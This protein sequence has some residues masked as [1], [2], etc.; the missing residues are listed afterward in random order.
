MESYDALRDAYFTLQDHGVEVTRAM[1][2]VS[3]KSIYF[4]DPDGNGL[5][6]YYELPNALDMFRNGREDRDEAITFTR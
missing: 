1:D 2:H 6:I 5:E 4:S 3:Q